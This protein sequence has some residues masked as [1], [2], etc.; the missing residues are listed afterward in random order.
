MPIVV[1]TDASKFALGAVLEQQFQDGIHPVAYISK[2]LSPAEQNYA[3]HNSEMLG[4]VHAVTSWRCY[5]HGR[6]F[7][8]QT[9]HAPLKHFFTQEKL[10]PLQV[11]WLEK[12]TPYDFCIVPIKGKANHVADGLSRRAQGQKPDEDYP[13]ELIKQF[14]TKKFTIANISSI[15][16]ST[17]ITE[18]IEKGYSQDAEFKNIYENPKGSFSKNNGLLYFKDKLCIPDIPLRHDL[19]HDFHTIASMGHLGESKTRHRISKHYHW[20]SL[21]DDVHKYVTGCRICPQTKSRNQKPY[22]LLQPIEPPLSK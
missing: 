10:S 12:L 21:R 1:T 3:T 14:L 11:R 5:L 4:I 16:A 19:L 22:G 6:K 8:V 20:K 9:D 2:T 15:R 13:K 17:A 18:A 7:I